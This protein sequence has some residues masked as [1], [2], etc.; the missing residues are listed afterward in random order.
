MIAFSLTRCVS[1]LPARFLLAV[2]MGILLTGSS[3]A[4]EVEKVSLAGTWTGGGI[5]AFGSGDRER[6]RC[7]AVYTARSESTYAMTGTCTIAS[8]N[9]SQTAILKRTSPNSF[10]GS[11]YNQEYQVSGTVTVSIQGK[12]QRAV[13]SSSSGSVALSLKK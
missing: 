9:L 3:H 1:R 8:G 10:S 11:F 4:V 5:V 2:A 12:N 6:A 7:H 13:L